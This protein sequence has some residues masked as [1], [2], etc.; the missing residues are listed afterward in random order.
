MVGTVREAIDII[1]NILEA[2]TEYSMIQT[3]MRGTILLG[4]EGARHS[5][6]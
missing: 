5:Y 3:A 4:N 1:S 6:G 2:S